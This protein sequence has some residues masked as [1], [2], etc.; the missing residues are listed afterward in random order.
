[1]LYTMFPELV[2]IGYLATKVRGRLA[3]AKADERG[4][5][6]EGI[7]LTVVL[8]LMAIATVFIINAKVLV[9]SPAIPTE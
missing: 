7:V 4:H 1:M 9:L 3:L 8:V 6:A 5:T 2:V